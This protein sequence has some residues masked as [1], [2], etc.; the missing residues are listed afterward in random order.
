MA[1]ETP[2]SSGLILP[3]YAAQA[4]R[5]LEVHAPLMNEEYKQALN[6]I[7]YLECGLK[8]AE[9]A[10]SFAYQLLQDKQVHVQEMLATY[11]HFYENELAEKVDNIQSFEHRVYDAERA[12]DS[13]L[14]NFNN[15]NKWK[16]SKLILKKTWNSQVRDYCT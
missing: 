11:T 4:Q 10:A 3:T 5:L 6:I 7:Q 1:D 14:K 8:V 15:E 13:T 16:R 2:A 12:L 9:R